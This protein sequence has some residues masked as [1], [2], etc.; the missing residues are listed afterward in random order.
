MRARMQDSVTVAKNWL[1]A[2]SAGFRTN[3]AH[4]VA[5]CFHPHGFLRDVLTFTWDLRTL[6]GRQK[7]E[8]YLSEHGGLD[9]V[10]HVRLTDDAYFQPKPFGMGIEFGYEYETP[11]ARGKG[12]VRLV[13]EVGRGWK[14]HTV[15]MIVMD[16]KGHEEPTRRYS[17]EEFVGGRSW[18]EYMAELRTSWEREPHVLI[19]A[20]QCMLWVAIG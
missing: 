4:A 11:I 3:D 1:A 18:G 10:A 15:S 13:H 16:L 9:K 5:S 7:I 14:G 17:F 8:E 12:M 19:S 20:Y 2:F 6:E